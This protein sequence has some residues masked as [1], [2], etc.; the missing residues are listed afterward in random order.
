M[1]FDRIKIKLS[2]TYF[3]AEH[4]N[5]LE[6]F[7]FLKKFGKIVDLVEKSEKIFTECKP[8]AACFIGCRTGKNEKS[9]SATK[10]LSNATA[11]QVMT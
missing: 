9:T 2:I 3:F 4:L 6:G 5:S 1:L 10:L 11:C 8:F 7:L